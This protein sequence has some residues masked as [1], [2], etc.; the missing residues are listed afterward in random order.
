[1]TTEPLSA[2]LMMPDLWRSDL[3][4]APGESVVSALKLD[5]DLRLHF[6][7]GMLLVTERRLLA[8]GL[9]W[10]CRTSMAC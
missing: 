5:L 1:M 10:N 6:V 9:D 2:D 4:L 3:P 8:R 7:D